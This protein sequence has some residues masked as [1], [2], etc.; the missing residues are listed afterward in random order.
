MKMVLAYFKKHRY[1][2]LFLFIFG[3]IINFNNILKS[4]RENLNE[5]SFH[6]DAPFWIFFEGIIIFIFISVIKKKIE[7]KSTEYFPSLRKYLYYF[8]IGFIGYMLYYNLS[9]VLVSFIFNTFDRNFNSW[10]RIVFLN[11]YRVV[12]FMIFGGF[13]L[14][15]LYFM[16]SKNYRKLMNE[17]Q[18]SDAKSKIQQ[19]QNQLNPH[20]LFNNLNILDQ[21]IEEDQE[22]A[23]TFLS[24]FSEVYRFSL[25]NSN[26]ELI[27]LQEELSFTKNYFKLMEEKYQDYYKLEIDVSIENLSTIVPPFCLQILVENAIIHNLGT[28]EN[29]VIIRVFWEDG[30]KIQNN[31]IALKRKK[32]TNG[33]ALKN[34]QEQFLLLFKESIEIEETEAIFYVKL[35]VLKTN[36]YV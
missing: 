34:L 13:S 21:L 24:Q 14:A 30:I 22:K 10:N 35:P 32:K 25:I 6:P 16:D 11:L 3:W 5:I 9:S 17:Y 4:S 2:F 7:K 33:V 12:D 20:F 19:L 8:G 15:Y 27:S 18:I 1:F 28:T 29:P 36:E 26:K 23:S 31:K